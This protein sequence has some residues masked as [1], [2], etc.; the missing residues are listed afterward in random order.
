MKISPILS[1]PEFQRN[2]WQE[3]TQHRLI[4]GVMVLGILAW[5]IYAT[6]SSNSFYWISYA[7]IFVWGIKSAS[8]AIQKELQQGTWD[9]QRISAL[10]PFKFTWGKLLGSTSYTW[11]LAGLSFIAYI[12]LGA[13]FEERIGLLLEH[14]LVFVICGLLG[15]YIAMALSLNA[16]QFGRDKNYSFRYFM[17]GLIISSLFAYVLKMHLP[18]NAAR[19]LSEQVHWYHLYMNAYPFYLMLVS[20]LLGWSILGSY[21]L[22]RT[23]FQY[24]NLP[25]VWLGFCLFWIIFISGFDNLNIANSFVTDFTTGLKSYE[26]YSKLYVAFI[27]SWV[28][29]YLSLFSQKYQT[30][31]YKKIGQLIQQRKYVDSLCALPRWLIASICFIVLY[32][33]VIIF[34]EINIELNKNISDLTTHLGQTPKLIVHGYIFGTTALLLTIRDIL[35]VHY[36]YFSSNPKRAVLSSSVYLILLYFVMPSLFIAIG[37]KDLNKML[38][39]THE[40]VGIIGWIGLFSQVGLFGWLVRMRFRRI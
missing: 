2:L 25:F 7:I 21:R 15:Q 1:N 29:L 18:D 14:Y 37:L 31:I 26:V 34:G 12:G 36:F 40:H 33:G 8:E 5:L 38:L 23:E 30:I 32:I 6:S 16:I 17:S 3:L 11:Y 22:I 9:Y 28:L 10:S 35:L 27:T 24:K 13:Y 39:I 4:G 19:M 20:L